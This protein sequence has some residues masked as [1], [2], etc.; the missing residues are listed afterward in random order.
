MPTA[1]P[2][3]KWSDVLLDTSFLIALRGED[4]LESFLRAPA[5]PSRRFLIPVRA[6]LEYVDGTVEGRRHRCGRLLHVLER[7]SDVKFVP[8]EHDVWQ[9][10][11]RRSL[12]AV[13]VLEK[14][15]A[16]ALDYLLRHPGDEAFETQ[17]ANMHAAKARFRDMHLS[18][19]SVLAKRFK[20]AG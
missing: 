19:R 18:Q 20:D 7:R 3:L 16:F 9:I 17:V 10:E 15:D 11:L 2:R 5:E 12:V 1:L 14:P 4:V 13:P 6:F 8:A